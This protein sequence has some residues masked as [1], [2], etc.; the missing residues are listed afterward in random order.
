[1]F[2]ATVLEKL[3]WIL[4]FSIKKRVFHAHSQHN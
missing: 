1:M 2:A 3:L 4:Y